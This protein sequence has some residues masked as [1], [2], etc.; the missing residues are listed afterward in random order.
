MEKKNFVDAVLF[1]LS[2]SVIVLPLSL[3]LRHGGTC[4]RK[5]KHRRM[6]G[7]ERALGRKSIHR[8]ASQVTRFQIK[9]VAGQSR[10]G[11]DL[12]SRQSPGHISYSSATW[13]LKTRETFLEGFFEISVLLR[14]INLQP[15]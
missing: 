9:A 1:L 13:F 7:I 14:K 6:P 3:S 5:C 4:T 15:R 8:C 2:L 11:S 10:T 12:V